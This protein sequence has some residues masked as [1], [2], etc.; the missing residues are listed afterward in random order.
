MTSTLGGANEVTQAAMATGSV[1]GA[2]M[3]PL[4]VELATRISLGQMAAPTDATGWKELIAKYTGGGVSH[5]SATPD[6]GTGQA[7]AY[8]TA[9]PTTQNGTTQTTQPLGDSTQVDQFLNAIKA[10]ESGGNY[11][12]YN[13]A[14]G[15][16]GAYQYIQSTW[17]SYAKAAGYAQY[18]NGPAS[19]APPQVQDAVA[20]Y[21]AT[22]LFNQSHS[23]KTAAE[24]WY[25]PAWANDPTKQ[26]S[27]PYPSAGNTLTIGDYG[28]Q[29]V[30]K[31][32]IGSGTAPLS[33]SDAPAYG[34]GGGASQAVAFARTQLGVPYNAVT[35]ENPGVGFDCSGL[36]QMAYQKAGITL[37][38]TAQAQ[39]DAT[40]KVSRDQ[41]QPGDLVFYGHGP[42]QVEHVG[43]YLGN[44]Q[45]LDAPHTGAAVRVEKLW[46]GEVGFSRPTATS[47]GAVH[48]QVGVS[49]PA[50]LHDY[51]STLSQVQSAMID[52]GR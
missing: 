32:G 10:H 8:S 47:L 2:Q 19:Q 5:T 24:S 11:Q 37:P 43:I 41:A 29:I 49:S 38:R 31:M 35:N 48:P 18:A 51:Y 17:S 4:A 28:N 30:G 34:T 25:Y 21:N 50:V 45:M 12:A 14:G 39:Y 44:G 52:A 6:I 13:S 22:E 36:T 27:V 23:W 7:L 9:S 40:V 15:A 42:Q 33:S 26:N 3:A 46:G 20:R 16:S 1:S